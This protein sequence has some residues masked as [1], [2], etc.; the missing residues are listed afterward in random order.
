MSKSLASDYGLQVT[1]IS[2]IP[3]ISAISAIPEAAFD[4]LFQA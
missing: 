4:P 2:A 3:A 1:Q